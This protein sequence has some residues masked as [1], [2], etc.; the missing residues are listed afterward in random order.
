MAL[1]LFS[2][3]MLTKLQEGDYIPLYY[4][5]NRGIY[6]AEEEG[7]GDKD[8]LTLVQTDKGSTFQTSASVKAKKHKVKDESLSWEEF[9]QANY[10]MLNAMRQQDWPVEQLDMIRHFWLAIEGH[11]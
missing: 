5:T 6:E 10:R 4:F 11:D 3:H 8:L 1:L 9:S 7:S 2:Q